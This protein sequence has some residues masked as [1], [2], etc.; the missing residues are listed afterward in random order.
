MNFARI[1]TDILEAL[2]DNFSVFLLQFNT[3]SSDISDAVPEIKYAQ[4]DVNCLAA[5][6]AAEEGGSPRL[7]H[8]LNELSSSALKG[9]HVTLSAARTA[10]RALS[11][12][13]S[14][15]DAGSAIPGS[16]IDQVTT[17]EALGLTR[18]LRVPGLRS[19]NENELFTLAYMQQHCSTTM[20][21]K[22]YARIK[23][24]VESQLA[25]SYL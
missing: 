19:F 12:F 2:I 6:A 20:A 5:T 7:A 10:A 1:G 15:I 25:E 14:A 17:Y 3:Q 22:D 16:G 9:F 11:S 21:D 4:P 24:H 8:E 13:V 18:R 23:P